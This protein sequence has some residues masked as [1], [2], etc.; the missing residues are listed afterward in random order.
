[1]IYG[2]TNRGNGQPMDTLR[3]LARMNKELKKQKRKADKLQ[4]EYSRFQKEHAYSPIVAEAIALLTDNELVW[5][6]DFIRIRELLAQLIQVASKQAATHRLA[7][8]LS[9]Q[10]VY[11]SDLIDDISFH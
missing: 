4:R 6:D 9:E 2:N 3:Q 10:L 5:S 11:G 7:E 1:M 8:T